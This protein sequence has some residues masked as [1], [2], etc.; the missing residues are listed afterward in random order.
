VARIGLIQP[1]Y[2]RGFFPAEIFE[3]TLI[4]IISSLISEIEFMMI[5]CDK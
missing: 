4:E 2:S 5:L 3:Q 1:E